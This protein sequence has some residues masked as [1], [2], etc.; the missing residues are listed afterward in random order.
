MS[1]K[2]RE[3]SH[4]R[5]ALSF[6]VAAMVA[7]AML[8]AGAHAQAA[9]EELPQ[10]SAVIE[11]LSPGVTEG[12]LLAE[13]AAHNAQRR[14]ALRGYSVFRTYQVVD[15]KGKVHAEE[16]GRMEFLAPDKKTFTVDTE[17]GSGLVRHMALN[18]LINS[19]IEA[20]AGKEHRDSAI[21][22][23]NYSLNLLGEQQLGPYRCFVA[24]AVPKRKD[25][26]LFEGKVWIDVNDYSVVRIEGHPAKKLSFW[27]QHADFVRQYQRIDG[28]WLPKKD[29]TLVQVRLYGKKILK[30]EHWNYLVNEGQNTNA[31]TAVREIVV[32]QTN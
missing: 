32:T 15:L 3:T 1:P 9:E 8:T 6:V 27:I 7:I 17:S 25:K 12:Q 22:T 28:F 23:D 24:E 11:S 18:P 21:S 26:Y 4:T 13:L 2:D 30:I 29:Q 5:L 19:E 20:A 14:S 31:R 16:V 10:L